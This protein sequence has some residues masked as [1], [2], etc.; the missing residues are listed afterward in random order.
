[1]RDNLQ[2][3]TAP[4]RFRPQ[5]A[6]RPEPSALQAAQRHG[7]VESAAAMEIRYTTRGFP[8]RLEWAAPP[9]AHSHLHTGPAIHSMNRHLTFN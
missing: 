4:Q 6:P 1:M 5:A 3:T 2:W 9:A 7:P 8:H